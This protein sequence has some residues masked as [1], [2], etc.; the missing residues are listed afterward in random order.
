MGLPDEDF[1]DNF[2]EAMKF[3]TLKEQSYLERDLSQMPPPEEIPSDELIEDPMKS[4][5]Q[6]IM[7]NQQS[8]LYSGVHQ[9]SNHES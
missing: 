5:M 8:M 9:T 4:V 2:N 3:Q 1:H 7:K 6:S